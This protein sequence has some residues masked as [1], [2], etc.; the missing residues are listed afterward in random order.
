VPFRLEGRLVTMS[1]SVEYRAKAR[2]CEERAEQFAKFRRQ[3]T[4]ARNRREVAD[5]ARL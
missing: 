3:G 5:H 1:K 2:E 4:A